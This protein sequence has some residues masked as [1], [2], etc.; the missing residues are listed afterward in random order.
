MQKV[1]RMTE[2]I[3][4]AT[5]ARAA[6]V[7]I[8]LGRSY[9]K[10][11]S[12]NEIE[13]E[14]I[15]QWAFG[16]LLF[17]FFVTFNRWIS[18]PNV[19]IEHAERGAAVCWE[20]FQDCTRFFFLHEIGHGYSQPLFYAALYAVMLLIVYCMW[21]KNWIAAHALMLPLLIWEILVALIFS[22]SDG[23]PYHYYH[24]VLTSAL[25]FAAHKEFFLK[26]AFIFLYFMSV[27][28]KL[29]S[30]WIL[31]TYFTALK[32]G[33]PLFPDIFT[34]LITNVVI[35]MQMVGAWFLVSRHQWLQR[36]VFAFFVAFH[37][38][39]A[40]FVFYFYPSVSLPT[41]LIMFGPM[42]RHTPIPFTKRAT[43]GWAILA[44]VAIFQVLGF[45]APGDR[46][47][48]LEAD[49]FGMFMFE[50]NHQCVVTV[51][52]YQHAALRPRTDWEASLG[53][54]CTSFYCMVKTT[55]SE[56]DGFFL[57][58]E[59]YESGTA[60]NRCY[61]Y[62]WW[63]RYHTL[64]E[65]DGNIARVSLRLDHSINGGPFY[66]TVDVENICEMSYRPFGGNSWIKQ[67]PEA[68]LIGYPVTNTY[69]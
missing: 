11:F 1:M 52:T 6:D 33:L 9:R 51:G 36:S 65:R 62:E 17:F 30:T 22:F 25:L 69:N 7:L 26:I 55:T 60:W 19:T 39:S 16:G 45:L 64:C 14:P 54:R 35:G 18:S 41:L 68:P 63:T 48:T 40:I 42:Y 13:N 27:T 43:V 2:R 34:P 8:P 28:T 24:I 12:V 66:R 50:A 53:T 21:R 32:D 15:L 44:L 29:D 56:V 58:E 49:K 5:K 4:R 23:A 31:G 61:P 38:Y 67:P 47:M 37:V 46:R 10:L 59:R 3:F 20:Y 57:R